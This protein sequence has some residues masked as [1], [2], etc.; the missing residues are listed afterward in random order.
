[1]TPTLVLGSVPFWVVP[2]VAFVEGG[3]GSLFLAAYGDA[4]RSVVPAAQLRRRAG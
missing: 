4:M 1:V 2:V 3:A